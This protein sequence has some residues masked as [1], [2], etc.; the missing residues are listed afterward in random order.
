MLHICLSLLSLPAPKRATLAETESLEGAQTGGDGGGRCGVGFLGDSDQLFP[1]YRSAHA[2]LIVLFIPLLS[3]HPCMVFLL[4]YP[5]FFLSPS[6]NHPGFYLTLLSALA[7]AHSIGRAHS[8][9]EPHSS[10]NSRFFHPNP[11]QHDPKTHAL[12]CSPRPPMLQTHGVGQHQKRNMKD[13]NPPPVNAGLISPTFPG[14][15][16]LWHDVESTDS[17]RHSLSRGRSGGI[18]YR[19]CM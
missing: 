18:T 17:T 13:K 15:V 4:Q 2:L 11:Q 6:I 8:G 3:I 10:R 14:G 7:S 9:S 12:C 16:A 1:H 5:H 19:T